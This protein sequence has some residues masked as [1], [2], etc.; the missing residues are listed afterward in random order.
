MQGCVMACFQ[1][2]LNFRSILAHQSELPAGASA[3]E[4]G[5][6]GAP[7]W[8]QGCADA[9]LLVERKRQRWQLHVWF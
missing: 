8:I 9:A 2:G 1:A 6:S 7:K 3:H 4:S 5:I